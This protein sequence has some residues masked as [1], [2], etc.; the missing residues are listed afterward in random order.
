MPPKSSKIFIRKGNDVVEFMWADVLG[1]GSV[2]MGLLGDGVEEVEFAVDASRGELRKPDLVTEAKLGRPKIT[3]HR[4]GK[5][6]LTGRVGLDASAVDRATV[7]GPPLAEIS[8]PRLMLEVLLPRQ[9]PEARLTPGPADIV[10]IVPEDNDLPLRCTV[11]CMGKVEYQMI[12]TTGTVFV[13]TSAWESTGAL[14]NDSHVWA[15]TLRSSRNDKNFATKLY[16][17]LVGPVK[18]GNPPRSDPDEPGDAR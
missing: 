7:E 3:F 6:K 14:E 18:W 11:S 2:A 17:M 4:T 8:A 15:W 12:E 16:M 9:L 10:L 5:Y 1:D 13:E